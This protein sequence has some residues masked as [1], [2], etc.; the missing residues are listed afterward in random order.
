MSDYDGKL[1]AC[2][3]SFQLRG[4]VVGKDNPRKNNGFTEGK[5]KDQVPYRSIRFLVKTNTDNIV[6]VELF[7]QVQE[8][9][10][11]YN[12]KTKESK[13]VTWAKRF[14]KASEGYELI[15]PT[16]DLIKKIDEDFKDGMSIVI[17]GETMFSE[18]TPVNSSVAQLQTRYSIKSIYEST[19]P[20]D[21]S[22]EKFEE[23]C[24]FIQEVVIREIEEIAV[25]K[26]LNVYAYVLENRGKKKPPVI[27]PA[28][29]EIN[30][31]TADI[32]FVRNM[33]ALK[34]GD[35]IKVNGKIHCRATTE[36]VDEN[37][38]WGKKEKVATSYH[39]A[40]EITG[41]YGETLEKKKYTEEDLVISNVDATFDGT[42][43]A[44]KKVLEQLEKEQ[45]E[46]NDELPFDLDE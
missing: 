4:I 16:Y 17:V 46:G 9:A 40:M 38:G 8:R 35:F 3:G 25:D 14:E 26:K 2:K 13:P 31:A 33:K 10:Y 5:T 19:A 22:D 15:L 27:Q 28:L 32:A 24:Y 37:D 30:T 43:D 45:A 23:E 12:R 18:Y 41:A 7:G 6:P 34:F 1:I 29:F 11:L 21:F 20:V 44:A 36:E 42:G 39:K